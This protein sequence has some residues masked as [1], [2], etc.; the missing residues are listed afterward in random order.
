MGSQWELEEMCYH[1]LQMS[2]ISESIQFLYV[3]RS[4]LLCSDCSI[5]TRLMD[6]GSYKGKLFNIWLW[7]GFFCGIRQVGKWHWIFFLFLHLNELRP[8]CF[9][10]EGYKITIIFQIT[11][12]YLINHN[13]RG[14]WVCCSVTTFLTQV[15]Q[16]FCW[17]VKG[18]IWRR[19]PKM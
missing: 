11:K 5:G 3:I 18:V 9:E 14:K 7:Q 12:K 16:S 4:L 10:Q 13:G 2:A 19:E 17:A 8:G 6:C 15:H 1:T